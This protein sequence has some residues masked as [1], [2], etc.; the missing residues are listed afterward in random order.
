M[1]IPFLILFFFNLQEEVPFKPKEDFEIKFDLTFKVR[2]TDDKAV[3]LN[4]T[5]AEHEK[6]TSATPLPFLKLLVKVKRLQQEEIKL[7]VIR[8]DKNTLFSKK[9]E[10]DMEFK[11]EVGFTDDLKDQVSG[12]RH[13]I[14]FL[15]SKKEVLSRIVIEFDKDGNYFVNG[16]KRGR[17]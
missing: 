7:K 15:S 2:T 8:D 9:T 6:R 17:V 10:P 1:I 12:Y 13:V 5:R 16:E 4:E 3:Y 11:L 14:Q